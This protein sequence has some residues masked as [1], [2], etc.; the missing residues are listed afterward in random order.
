MDWWAVM[1]PEPAAA[2]RICCVGVWS[3]R[4]DYD[5]VVPAGSAIQA[6]LDAAIRE[7][8]VERVVDE[9]RAARSITRL[10]Q[11]ATDVS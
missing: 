4:L 2:G 6:D 8:A 7:C 5:V 3:A 10:L 1:R 9:R 11:A